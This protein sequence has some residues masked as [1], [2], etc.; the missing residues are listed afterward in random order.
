MNPNWLV[1]TITAKSVGQ[2]ID[3]N[4]IVDIEEC[5]MPLISEHPSIFA[6]PW[7]KR[8]YTTLLLVTKFSTGQDPRKT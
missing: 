3:N 8:N 6:L 7:D 1:W 2:G 4:L 5:H